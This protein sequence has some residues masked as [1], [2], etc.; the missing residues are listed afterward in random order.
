MLQRI[1]QTE[2]VIYALLWGNKGSVG[3]LQGETVKDI[4]TDTFCFLC[5][6]V[7]VCREISQVIQHTK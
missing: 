5:V 2:Y 1:K 6:Y 4:F 7:C 3:N